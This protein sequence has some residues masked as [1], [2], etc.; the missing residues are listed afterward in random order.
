MRIAQIE[1]C[2]EAERWNALSCHATAYTDRETINLVWQIRHNSVFLYDSIFLYELLE[3][4]STSSLFSS[5]SCSCL[6]SNASALCLF[7]ST[8]SIK[9]LLSLIVVHRDQTTLSNPRVDTTEQYACRFG[10]GTQ[11]TNSMRYTIYP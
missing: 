6:S 9:I 11:L 2:R 5:R 8:E 1:Q 7:S 3:H 4:F 10:L